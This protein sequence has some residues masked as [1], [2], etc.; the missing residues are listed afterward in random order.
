MWFMQKWKKSGS[1]LQLCLRDAPDPRQT[2]LYRLSQRSTLHYFK[3][4]ILCGSSQDRY[5][6]P[7][8]ARLELCKAAVRDNSNLGVVYR[9]ENYLKKK[10]FFK[11]I[12]I[13]KRKFCI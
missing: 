8:S 11:N 5:V 12:F 6:P 4:V 3:N 10:H 9:Y 1:L 2:F 13:K 7:H